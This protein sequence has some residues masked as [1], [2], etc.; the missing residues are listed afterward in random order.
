MDAEVTNCFALCSINPRTHLPGRNRS[1]SFHPS[2]ANMSGG[3]AEASSCMAA[4]RPGEL[5]QGSSMRQP[6]NVEA[7]SNDTKTKWCAVHGL[8]IHEPVARQCPGRDMPGLNPHHES[9]RSC[10]APV[11][12]LTFAASRLCCPKAL[13]RYA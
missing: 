11:Q 9:I 1:Y 7:L 10:M 4:C 6:A 5:V 8:L 3:M 12:N 2:L 13:V